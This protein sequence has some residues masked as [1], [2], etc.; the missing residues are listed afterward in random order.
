MGA[1]PINKSECVLIL[2]KPGQITFYYFNKRALLYQANK[3][4]QGKEV[5]RNKLFESKNISLLSQ[6]LV[7]VFNQILAGFYKNKCGFDLFH[8]YA[9]LLCSLTHHLSPR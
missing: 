4:F 6:D 2:H 1:N 9:F 7:N 8:I 5:F 3:M